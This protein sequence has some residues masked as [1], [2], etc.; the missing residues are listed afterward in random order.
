MPK[1]VVVAAWLTVISAGLSVVV[2]GY[3]VLS[4]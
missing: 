3:R 1:V 4:K 2:L